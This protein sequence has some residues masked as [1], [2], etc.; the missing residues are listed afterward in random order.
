MFMSVWLFVGTIAGLLLVLSPFVGVARLVAWARRKQP[1][2]VSQGLFR[3][4]ILGVAA[5]QAIFFCLCL[6]QVSKMDLTWVE[7]DRVTVVAQRTATLY[8]VGQMF[9]PVLT[10]TGYD[11]DKI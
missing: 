6:G 7:Q 1:S 3:S 8:I 4:Y 9:A 10:L 2:A 5:S 11:I